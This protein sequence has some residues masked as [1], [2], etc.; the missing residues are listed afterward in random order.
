M[1]EHLRWPAVGR[2]YLWRYD[3]NSR[4]YSGWHMTADAAGCAAL[5]DVCTRIEASSYSCVLDIPLCIV[6][7]AVL[8]VPGAP[9]NPVQ[10]RMWCW[11]VSK[12]FSPHH[13][14]M[15]PSKRGESVSLEISRDQVA[16][17]RAGL[18]DISC[19]RGDYSIGRDESDPQVDLER[20]WFWWFGA[21]SH[22][23]R[24]IPG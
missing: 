21:D 16:R 11:R 1:A 23:C 10:P 13:W 12:R 22:K 7:A 4:N 9:G 20:L 19:G 17:L 14:S 18:S 6:T 8:A 15:I 24:T 5:L 3:P 2:V